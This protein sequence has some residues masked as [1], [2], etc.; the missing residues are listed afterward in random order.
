MAIKTVSSNRREVGA[1]LRSFRRRAGFERVEDVAEFIDV[2]SVTMGRI[3][4]GEA[5]IDRAKLRVLADKYDLNDHEREA[6]LEMARQTRGRR[7]TFPAYFSVKARALL[8]LEAEASDLLMVT[9]DLIPAYFQTEPYM[10]ALFDGNGEGLS[11]DEIDRLKRVRLDRQLILSQPRPPKIRAIIHETALRLPVGGAKVMREQLLHLANMC[12]H[13]NVEIQVQPASAGTY[14]GIG[15]TFLLMRMDN[16]PSTDR[17]QVETAGDS[18]YRDRTVN[19]EPYRLSWERKR[20]A[21][22]SLPAS[23]TLIFNTARN[24]APPTDR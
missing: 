11:Q 6:L 12:R 3:E 14:P 1:A 15:T 22:L 16:D 7:G 24:F 8:E 18:F 4:K 13:P 9:I 17:I 2:S 23:R 5:P 19:V 21:A 10:Q 20:V